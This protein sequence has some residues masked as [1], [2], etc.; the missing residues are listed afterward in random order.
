MSIVLHFLRE[1]VQDYMS[2]AACCSHTVTPLPGMSLASLGKLKP[3]G[4]EFFVLLV[5]PTVQ[6]KQHMA[7]GKGSQSN[8]LHIR[9]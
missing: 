6:S 5:I 3:E 2:F 4:R 8:I 1:A 9:V 7:D